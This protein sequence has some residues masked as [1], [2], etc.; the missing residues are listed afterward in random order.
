MG[1]FKIILVSQGSSR[2]SIFDC[3]IGDLFSPSWWP[4]NSSIH[5]N[6]LQTFWQR[7]K[8]V[9][10]NRNRKLLVKAVM[11]E[12]THKSVAIINIKKKK[13]AGF[14][15]TKYK[16]CLMININR[17]FNFELQWQQSRL[18]PQG[19]EIWSCRYYL[20]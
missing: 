15:N 10:S 17:Q 12:N 4:T 16:T 5:L 3:E 11:Y 18:F 8:T 1:L 20:G 2:N 6:W 9:L 7:E 19:E 14:S 13:Q